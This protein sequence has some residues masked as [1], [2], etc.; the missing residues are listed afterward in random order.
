MFYTGIGSRQT[1]QPYLDLMRDYAIYLRDK[2]I[3]RS[4]G[5]DGADTIFEQYSAKK[6]IY[7]PSNTYNGRKADN[8]QY[9]FDYRQLKEARKLLDIYYLGYRSTKQFIN[10]LHARNIFQVLGLYFDKPSSFLICYTPDGLEDLNY[11]KHSGGTRTAIFVAYTNNIPIFNIKNKHSQ[12]K[13][14]MFMSS[15]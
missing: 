7:L 15:L 3:V 12:N 13:L 6:E 5:A 2:A 9:I 8:L 10:D 14:E 1:P 4:G 11:T